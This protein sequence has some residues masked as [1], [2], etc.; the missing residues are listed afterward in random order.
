MSGMIPVLTQESGTSAPVSQFLRELQDSGFSGDIAMDYASRLVV[1]T[2]N[3]VFQILPQAVLFP[4]QGSDVALVTSLAHSASHRTI[5]LSPRGGGTGTNGQSLNDGIVLDFSRYMNR[6]LEFSE[7]ERWVRVQPGVVL[8]E[9]NREMAAHGLFF[10]PHVAPGSRATIG[11]MI[12]T[13]AA[14][15][16]SRVYGKTSEH[17]L[18]TL[19]VWMDGSTFHSKPLNEAEFQEASAGTGAPAKALRLLKEI[20]LSKRELID[21]TFPKLKR[22]MTGYNLAKMYDHE[23]GVFHLNYLLAGS[24][25]SLTILTSA[26]LNL[27][28]IPK[29]SRLYALRYASFDDALQSATALLGCAPGAIETIDE[30]ILRLAQDDTIYPRVKHLVEDADARQPRAIN[31]VEFHA[32]DA[33]SLRRATEAFDAQLECGALGPVTGSLATADAREME[34]LWDLRKK[35][36]GLLG[37]SQGPRKPIPF[38]EDTVVPPAAL[39]SY[40]REMRALLDSEG[41]T[42][43]M[44]GHVD[45]GCLHVRPA[46]DMTDEADAARMIRISDGVAKLVHSYGGII[47]GEHGKGFRSHYTP[48][49]FGEELYADC[50]RIK[51][52]FDPYNQL[53]PGKIAVSPQTTQQLA[54]IH[55][56]TRGELDRQ[57]G[58]QTR[59]AF[60]KAIECNGNAACLDAARDRVMCPSSKVRGDR[61]HSPKGRAALLREWLRRLALRDYTPES[62][63]RPGLAT[64][65]KRPFIRLWSRVRGRRA[66]YDFSHEVFDSMDGCLG[67]KACAT[68][69]PVQ[70][71]IPAL[72]S[73]FL[74]EYH[75]R[76]GRPL[77]D[78]FVASMEAWLPWMARFPRLSNLLTHNPLAR[79]FLRRCVGIVDAPRL[80]VP[81]AATQLRNAGFPWA[82]VQDAMKNG[83]AN[84]VLVVQDAFTTFFD[85]Q[86]L[87]STCELLRRL[88]FS[89]GVIPF[90][91]N[92]KGLAVKGFLKRF[93]T[94]ARAHA[95]HLQRFAQSGL[96]MLAIEPAVALTY[97]D[98]YPQ[99][100]PGQ[101]TLPIQSLQGWLL[102]HQEAWKNALPQPAQGSEYTFFGHCTER[103]HRPSSDDAWRRVFAAFGA[104]LRLQDVGCCGMCGSFGHERSHLSESRGVYRMS[105]QPRVDGLQGM[106]PLATGHSCRSQIKRFSQA[107]AQHPV[108]VLNELLTPGPA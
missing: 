102:E 86:V 16:G 104:T 30:H 49:F 54:S 87:L 43:G 89:V 98:E 75:E 85:A 74:A 71:D 94:Q 41:L 56:P 57:I 23:T 11:G 67:C 33:E 17:I 14:G 19:S 101:A 97:Q 79:L 91:P 100:L 88:G 93:R 84:R 52:A 34:A 44:F 24:E 7:Q 21:A 51:E 22:F 83:P 46:L 53:N 48:A 62:I 20:A 65:L 27:E 45:V 47:W 60:S 96:P 12:S 35:G 105:W 4:R 32:Q 68:K 99:H 64:R 61:R 58:S 9:L 2:D 55:A 6:I 5:S 39:E 31:L 37:R 73:R 103:T 76:Y 80:A 15:K 78:Y 36:V 106:I 63:A 90:S 69:C 38:I 1:A 50:C 66:H 25:G 40:I 10:A 72:K 82:T 95:L 8:D 13:D 18:E 28:P 77:K 108:E 81:N 70:V 26:K 42:Y 107:T 59:H 3:S 92:G 29:A